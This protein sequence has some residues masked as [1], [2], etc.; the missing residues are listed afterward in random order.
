MTH[1]EIKTFLEIVK[2]SS[3]S[4]AAEK[5]FL[6]QST[7][8]HRL[9]VL[10]EELGVR[11][12]IRRQGH[13]SIELTNDGEAFLPLAYEYEALWERIEIFCRSGSKAIFSIG[14][15]ASMNDSIFYKLL[16][17]LLENNTSMTKRKMTFRLESH[18]T[19][20]LYQLLESGHINIAFLRNPQENRNFV[21]E[22]FFA[23]EFRLIVSSRCVYTDRKIDLE[24]L[25]RKREIDL[26]GSWGADFM[27]WH[28]ETFGSESMADISIN[29]VFTIPKYLT[30]TDQWAIVPV[31]VAEEL[32][33]TGQVQALEIKNPPPVLY[34]YKVYLKS[35][36]RLKS[37]MFELF[38]RVLEDFMDTM[39]QLKRI[40]T[41]YEEKNLPDTRPY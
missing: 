2:Y 23:E 28:D 41:I 25:D 26:A 19:E 9:S 14:C 17:K 5:L 30:R 35:Q 20:E 7:V 21:I 6:T 40:R 18:T 32:T 24:R 39:P 29:S 34:C 13:R 15:H 37:E 27:R 3:I 10:E 31:S 22:P 12:I 33:R 4:K 36:N 11:L 16:N 8:S 1:W 38:E